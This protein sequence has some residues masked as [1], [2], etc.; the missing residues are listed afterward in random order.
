[1][2]DIHVKGGPKADYRTNHGRIVCTKGFGA[3]SGG[4]NQFYRIEREMLSL[5]ETLIM[6]FLKTLI[7][8]SIV[9]LVSSFEKAVSR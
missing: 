7:T 5:Y 4:Q 9:H 8:A 6:N 3:P 1:M 2:S